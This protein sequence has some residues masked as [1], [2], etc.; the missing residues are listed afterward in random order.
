VPFQENISRTDGQRSL[1]GRDY[2]LGVFK[3]R[4]KV[5]SPTI[6]SVCA[7]T[8]EGLRSRIVPPR[9]REK[10][11]PVGWVLYEFH[12]PIELIRMAPRPEEPSFS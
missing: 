4:E 1:E 12:S 11:L 6:F 8:L 9:T 5:S 3:S 7:V 2:V 10:Y